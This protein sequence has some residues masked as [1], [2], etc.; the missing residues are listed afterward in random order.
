VRVWDLPTRVF[1]WL[2]ALLIVGSIITAKIG[3]NAMQWHLRFGLMV[4]ALLL[5]RLV[6]GFVGGHWSRFAAFLYSPRDLM[7]YLRGDAGPGGRFDVGHSPLGALSV[8]ALLA[9]LIAQVATGLVAD[10]PC[11]ADSVPPPA[12]VS[13]PAPG[14]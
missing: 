5:F 3:G 7:A 14:E 4:L 2:L 13:P 12:S 6:W 1:H 9:L 11:P 8:F 10:T